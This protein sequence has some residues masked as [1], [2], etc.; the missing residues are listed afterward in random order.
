MTSQTLS[1]YSEQF[2]PRL[3]FVIGE[4]FERQL[5]LDVNLYSN[6][7]T[8]VQLDTPKLSYGTFVNNT[9]PYI[10]AT[11]ILFQSSVE[12]FE[13]KV[14][15][16]EGVSVIFPLSDNTQINLPYD[17][18]AAIFFMLSRYEEYWNFQTDHHGRF[19]A[20]N[21]IAYQHQFLNQ[22]IVQYWVK[23]IA[24]LL[25]R[26][27]P[28][29]HFKER[30]YTFKAT[31]DIDVAYAFKN[32]NF[33]WQLLSAGKDIFELKFVNF[34]VR[35]LVLIGIMKD[36]YDTYQEL[37]E[38]IQKHQLTSIFF[39]QC[40]KYKGNY[41]KSL[42]VRNEFWQQFIDRIQKFAQIGI[43]PSYESNYSKKSFEKE[44]DTFKS[45]T[46]DTILNSRQH[47]LKLK[48]PHTYRNLCFAGITNDYTMG[49]A[50]ECGFRAGTC[51]PFYFF[52]LEVNTPT[53]LLIHPFVMMDGTM[54][55]YMKLDQNQSLQLFH[56]YK[57]VIKSVHGEMTILC[58]NHT[59][60]DFREWR[61]W[62]KVFVQM[63]NEGNLS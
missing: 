28:P 29:I 24:D 14:I 36:P 6:L 37:F 31:F 42:V 35:I 30:A 20:K 43:H 57:N 5:G 51:Y 19:E 33:L 22:P 16:Y 9:I 2:S 38:I 46:G 44:I 21:S 12:Y 32:R 4:V 13:V 41:D 39:I 56:H 45:F 8:F 11:H 58:H 54:K 26:F 53:N 27:Y 18:L 62:K 17:P 61:G 15:D 48:F 10:G 59:F 49:F 25:K 23:H 34:I 3:M 1:I 40:G 47:F 52:D 63:L 60:S 7:D 55:D 50:D